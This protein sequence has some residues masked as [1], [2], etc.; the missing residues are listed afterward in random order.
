MVAVHTLLHLC[1]NTRWSNIRGEYPARGIDIRGLGAVSQSSVLTLCVNS[2]SMPQSVQKLIADVREFGR[3]PKRTAHSEE[4]RRLALRIKKMKT[5]GDLPSAALEELQAL[6]AEQKASKVDAVMADVRELGRWPVQHSPSKD[7]TREAER[8]LAQRVAG[9]KAEG[10]LPSAALE[11]LQSLETVALEERM[12]ERVARVMADVRELG[13]CPV[14]FHT[15]SK[16]PTREAERLLAKR[17]GELKAKDLPSPIA[18]E[19][20]ALEA[21]KQ[22]HAVN[23]TRSVA[24]G[25]SHPAV[26]LTCSAVALKTPSP[27][28]RNLKD[29]LT[30]PPGKRLRRKTARHKTPYALPKHGAQLVWTSSSSSTIA[31]SSLDCGGSEGSGETSSRPSSLYGKRSATEAGLAEG[32]CEP[33]SPPASLDR[34]RSATEAGLGEAPAEERD[35]PDGATLEKEDV[36]SKYWYLPE[37]DISILKFVQANGRPLESASKGSYE[38]KLAMQ[39]RKQW[40]VLHQDTRDLLDALKDP[41]GVAAR[42]KT[43]L[44]RLRSQASVEPPR[45]LVRAL[46]RIGRLPSLAALQRLKYNEDGSK[47]EIW[48]IM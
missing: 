43:D 30:M 11:E 38:R 14:E 45:E 36:E 39:I 35:V 23:L 25:G 1:K 20:E 42:A 40:L 19:L 31:P 32:S 7:P 9:L 22:H 12:A 5:S 33:S 29:A 47:S 27:K 8:I 4:E 10:C 26:D 34:K 18:E 3:W 13:R 2:D 44:K 41:A 16:D 28:R 21:R 37:F 46:E 48:T 17:V 15:P 6:Q 24:S